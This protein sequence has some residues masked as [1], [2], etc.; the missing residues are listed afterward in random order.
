MAID[1][2]KY[3]LGSHAFETWISIERAGELELT[4]ISWELKVVCR[5]LAAK[6]G[7]WD[8]FLSANPVGTQQ[9]YKI[10]KNRKSTCLDKNFFRDDLNTIKSNP[11]QKT[12]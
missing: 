10:Q 8:N 1:I 7:S 6:V 12:S 5:E 2:N 3:V 4:A 11:M 9:T